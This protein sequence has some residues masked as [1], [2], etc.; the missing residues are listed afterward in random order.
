VVEQKEA[1]CKLKRT[2][3]PAPVFLGEITSFPAHYIA[4]NDQSFSVETVKLTFH[5]FFLGPKAEYPIENKLVWQ[6]RQSCIYDLELEG[7]TRGVT[8]SRVS[9]TLR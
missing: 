3:Q 6:L 8:F 1:L 9:S 7:D 2:F 5:S 4:F